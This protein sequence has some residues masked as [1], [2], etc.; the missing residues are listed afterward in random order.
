MLVIKLS[1]NTHG[2]WSKKIIQ[3]LKS[4]MFYKVQ[5]LRF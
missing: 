3:L 2:Y 1:I 5:I 4:V